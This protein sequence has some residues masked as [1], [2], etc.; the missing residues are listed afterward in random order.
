MNDPAQLSFD[1]FLWLGLILLQIM[2][3]YG[4]CWTRS[5]QRLAWFQPPVVLSVVFLYYTVF[6]PL[7]ALQQGAWND[8]GVDLRYSFAISWQGAAI[9]FAGFLV[10][11]GLVRLRLPKPSLSTSFDPHQAWRLGRNLNVSGLA[12]FALISGPR[13]LVLLNPF[14]ARQAAVVATG[15]DLGPFANYAGLTINLL[16]P[17]ILLLTAAWIKLRRNSTELA[18]WILAASG[19]YTTLGFRYRLVLLL[20]GMLILWFLARGR[21]PSAVIVIPSILGLLA[22]GGLIGLTRSYGMGLDLTVIEGLSFWDIV[23]A[24]FSESQIFLT[25]GAVMTLVPASIP[26]VGVTPLVNTLLFPIPSSLLPIKNSSEY[27]NSAV[28]FIYGSDARAMGSAFMNYAEYFL[29]GGWPVLIAGY[30]L[31]GWLCRLLWFWF[32]SRRQEPIAQVSYVCA[33]VYLYVIVSR[34]Y[35]PQ[36]VMLFFFTVFPLFVYYYRIAKPPCPD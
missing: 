34:G 10:G 25:S 26:Y 1:E 12:L 21:Q 30:V 16:I 7:N 27:L 23:L 36:V 2:G 24:G 11:Y 17:G 22:M 18:L 3:L 19:I 4:W 5:L 6:G 8:R 28:A 31:L 33:V 35:L 14:T 29:M 9:A 13:F 15:L 32:S 20:S